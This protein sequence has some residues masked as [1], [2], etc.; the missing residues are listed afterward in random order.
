MYVCVSLGAM[1]QWQMSQLR[2]IDLSNNALYIS[3]QFIFL[4]VDDCKFQ[5]KVCNA[6]NGDDEWLTFAR[7]VIE[8]YQIN[9]RLYRNLTFSFF[10]NR[11]FFFFF[12]TKKMLFCFFRVHCAILNHCRCMTI[13]SMVYICISHQC[14]STKFNEYSKNV[15]DE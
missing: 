8:S 10:F 13:Y 12:V 5:N 3:S 1:L 14:L 15:S 9:T 6:N 2:S 4:L 11:I 7:F